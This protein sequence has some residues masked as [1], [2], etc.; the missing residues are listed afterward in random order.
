[1]TK[2]HSYQ[3]LIIVFSIL[4]GLALGE[5]DPLA[6]TA[7]KLI[8]PFLMLMLFGLFL[9]IDTKEL[10][11]SLRQ[12][13]F[14]IVSIVFNFVWTPILAYGLGAVFLSTYLP[15][16]IG[17]VMLMVTPCTDWYLVFTRI[18]NGNVALSTTILPLNLLF[19]VLLL[20]LYLLLFFGQSGII[21]LTP[22][23]EGIVL[24]LVLPFAL[25]MLGRYMG[26]KNGRVGS[27]LTI[28]EKSQTVFL[29]LAISAMFASN[30]K[31]LAE[32]P[33]VILLLL[34]PILIFF[35]VTFFL[36]LWASK[37]LKFNYANTV[38]LVMVTMARNSPIALAIAVAVFPAEPM[39]ALALVI[40]PLIE[41][42]ILFLTSN[43]LTKQSL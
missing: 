21:A 29:A 20:P 41:L 25:A 3:T 10:R 14:F 36:A 4:V 6:E 16:W 15:L 13:I 38:S 35:V 24:V 33:Q 31:S 12:R 26:A 17:F 22:I 1:M 7:G 30:G 40:G 18:A 2:T 42:P 19:Q 39:I 9:G 28:I 32:H 8:M 34:V 23:I 37:L 43:I 11:S 5:S 27:F